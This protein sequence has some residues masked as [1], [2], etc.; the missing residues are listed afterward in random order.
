MKWIPQS[1]TIKLEGVE[2]IGYSA[3]TFA[4]T[5]DPGLISQLDSFIENVEAASHVKIAALGIARDD[6]Q[7]VFRLYGS[8]GVMGKMEPKRDALSH[9]IGILAE[10]VAKTQEIA[11]A[12]LSL[13]RVTLLHSDFPGRLCREG[14]MAFPFSPSDIERGVTYQFCLNHVIEIADPLALFPIEYE[15]V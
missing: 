8:N 4:G 5:R 12:A 14:N 2:A 7:I 13:T 11:N 1:Y 15:E 10:V 3:I 9:E 6:Y